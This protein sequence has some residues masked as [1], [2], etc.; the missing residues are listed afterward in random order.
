MRRRVAD[1]QTPNVNFFL[2]FYG[3]NNSSDFYKEKRKYYSS[4]K[5]KDY[6]NYIQTGI[7]EFKDYIEYANNREKSSGIFNQN[8]LLSEKDKKQLREELRETKSVIWD[9]LIT[10]EENFGKSWCNSYEQAYELVKSELPKFFKRAGLNP[11]N[12][13]WYAGLHENTDN[14]HIHLS[15]FEK[16]PIRLRPGK[17]EK[18]FSNGKLSKTAILE[19]KAHLELAATDFKARERRNRQLIQEYVNEQLN[20]NIGL[21]LNNQLLSLASKFSKKC[22]LAYAS[23]NMSSLRSEIDSITNYLI[24]KS[25]FSKVAYEDFIDLAK[26]KDERFESYCKRNRCKQPFSFE[27]KYRQDI[28]R[29]LGNIV[30]DFA[31]KIK[32]MDNE[33]LKL[34]ASVLREKLMQKKKLAKQLNDCL[35]LANQFEYEVMSAFQEYMQRLD[36]SKFSR[37]VEEGIID[38]EM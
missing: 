22:S 20:E 6:I 36:E 16:V 15:F 21:I 35:R 33:R 10:F 23:K 12:M 19:F 28:Y 25:K 3:P 29:R 11:D 37:L 31:F 7:E 13:V 5:A 18:V 9:G 30:I 26:H 34:N 8:G 32:Q 27:K 14:R 38:F 2:N 24:N 1:N 4:N 17:E